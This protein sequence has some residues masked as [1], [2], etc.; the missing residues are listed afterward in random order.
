MAG[1]DVLEELI[2][3]AWRG[4]PFPLVHM[5]T[6]GSTDM[7]EHKRPDQDGWHVESTGANNL[8]VSA[9]I[10]FRNNIRPAE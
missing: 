1:A 9:S 6:A 5:D 4:V 7:V 2:G 8:V 3:P 10:P